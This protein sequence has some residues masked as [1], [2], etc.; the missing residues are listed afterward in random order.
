MFK[1]I[2]EAYDT[3]S[4]PHAKR[5]YDQQF[6]A[7]P[8][9]APAP[10]AKNT[11]PASSA[12]KNLIY[13][14]HISLEDAFSGGTKV[15]KYVRSYKGV[16]ET[17]QLTVEYPAGVRT[18]QKLR[19]RGSGESLHPQQTAGDLI[20]IIQVAPHPLY[21]LKGPDLH[22]TVPITPLDLYL[23]QLVIPTLRGNLALTTDEQKNLLDG[24][25]R[26][27]GRGFPVAESSSQCG[28][29]VVRFSVEVPEEIN[30]NLKRSVSELKKQ[31]PTTEALALFEKFLR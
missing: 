27:K 30:E 7:T 20:V 4:D 25:L 2:N 10:K 17:A 22:I 9:K 13:H 3:L 19:V 29:L 31:L 15:I 6:S 23:K 28:D 24:D 21:T 5:I 11:T 12:G 8:T 1:D 18:E 26:L 16:R 14:L